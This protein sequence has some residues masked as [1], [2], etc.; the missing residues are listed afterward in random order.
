MLSLSLSMQVE[1]IGI[2]DNR[3]EQCLASMTGKVRPI[4]AFSCINTSV[5]IDSNDGFTIIMDYGFQFLI[6]E[7]FRLIK[8]LSVRSGY[9][10]IFK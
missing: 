6:F 3:K 5:T 8:E 9:L 1:F 4:Q 7:L 10:F 2:C